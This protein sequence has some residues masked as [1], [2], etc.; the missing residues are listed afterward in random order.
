MMV[1]VSK[2]QV[3]DVEKS[4]EFLTS[5]K[6]FEPTGRVSKAKLGALVGALQQLGDIPSGFEIERLI[7]P[8]VTQLAE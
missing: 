6:F 3:E 8:G 7:L 4:Y 5:G 1:A 2:M